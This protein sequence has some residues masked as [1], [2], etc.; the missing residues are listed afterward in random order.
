MRCTLYT[1]CPPVCSLIYDILSLNNFFYE[2]LCTFFINKYNI[3]LLE[4]V[5]LSKHSSHDISFRQTQ[6]YFINGTGKWYVNITLCK[7]AF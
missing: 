5:F 3:N 4:S 7:W 2:N 1:I 6:E